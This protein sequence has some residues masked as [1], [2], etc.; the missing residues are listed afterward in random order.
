MESPDVPKALKLAQS[1]G[2]DI[3]PK[4]VTYF[5]SHRTIVGHPDR[6][7][8]LWQ[9]Q[10]YIALGRSAAS[11]TDFYKLPSSRVVELGIQ[12]AI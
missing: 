4:T 12:M 10:I 8:P 5:I 11:A 7:V 1:K 3:D 9:E 2:L 6:G